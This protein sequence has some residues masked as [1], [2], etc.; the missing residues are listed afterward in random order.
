MR[1]YLL[2]ALFLLAAPIVAVAANDLNP[3]LVELSQAL[4][5]SQE[6]A[7]GVKQ[8]GAKEIRPEQYEEYSNILRQSLHEERAGEFGPDVVFEHGKGFL[9]HYAWNKIMKDPETV[10]DHGR[11]TVAR[12]SKSIF[13]DVIHSEP[14]IEWDPAARRWNLHKGL[15]ADS[16]ARILKPFENPDG[17]ITLYRA[18]RGRGSPYR[19]D[20]QCSKS[21]WLLGLV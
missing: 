8:L 15:D 19:F 5:S 2:L 1:C 12:H 4:L 9:G 13:K 14:W 17:S 7:D 11:G 20:A 16:L 10:I 18:M 3:C 6:Y 21:Y